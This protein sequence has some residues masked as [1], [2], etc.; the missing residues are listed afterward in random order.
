LEAVDALGGRVSVS[1]EQGSM[2]GPIG[3]IRKSPQVSF[4]G[5]LRDTHGHSHR[6]IGR[7]CRHRSCCKGDHVL[8]PFLSIC[9]LFGNDYPAGIPWPRFRPFVQWR[10]AVLHIL[11]DPISASVP[12]SSLEFMNLS[13]VS[14]EIFRKISHDHF[15]RTSTTMRTL[16]AH[17]VL[18]PEEGGA[19]DAIRV[20]S[21]RL[22]SLHPL[23]AHIH[24]YVRKEVSRWKGKQG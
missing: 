14:G 4:Y 10:R 24:L 1:P 2:R 21:K 15:L 13:E 19:F 6:G 7:R 18:L 5:N 16:P 20:V 23:V 11:S 8:G 12:D 3:E 17:G 9:R 22:F